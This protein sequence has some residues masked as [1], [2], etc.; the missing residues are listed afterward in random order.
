MKKLFRFFRF[1]FYLSK[2]KYCLFPLVFFSAVNLFGQNYNMRFKHIGIPEGLSNN[3]IT[4]INQDEYHYIWIAT[5]RGLNRFDGLKV[6]Q[7]IY[8]LDNN[9]NLLNEHIVDL[10]PNIDGG[11]WIATK[12]GLLLHKNGNFQ[13]YRIIE[14]YRIDI[15]KVVRIN[16]QNWFCTSYGIY[17]YNGETNNFKKIEIAE[18]SDSVYAF[19]NDAEI[20]TI[21]LNTE[22]D[23]LWICTSKGGIYLKSLKT[24]VI[25]PYKLQHSEEQ[26]SNNVF[27]ND[28]YEDNQKN[29]W[30][31]STQ[32]LWIKHSNDVANEKVSFPD[33]DIANNGVYSIAQDSEGK[34]WCS[35][36]D[37]GLFVIDLKNSITKRFSAED[38]SKL[39]LSSGFI[40]KIFIDSQDNL[41][42]GHQEVGIDYSITEYHQK[43]SYY[44]NV[45]DEQ[46]FVPTPVRKIVPINNEK[47]LVVY[48]EA[49]NPINK[50][51]SIIPIMNVVDNSRIAEIKHVKLNRGN[52][53]ITHIL[54][55]NDKFAVL[56]YDSIYLFNND[57]LYKDEAIL[58]IIPEVVLFET[59]VMFPYIQNDN[60]WILG[61]HLRRFDLKTGKEELYMQD[62]NLDRFIID[63]HGLLWGAAS[64]NGL[65][66]IDLK[67]KKVLAQFNNDPVYEKSISD[68]NINC[69][70]QD[71]E[72]FIWVGTEFGLNKVQP[73]I[74]SIIARNNGF[75]NE[76]LFKEI[77]FKRFKTTDG[78]SNNAVKSILEDN[79]KRLWLGTGN[80]ISIVDMST[81]NIFNLG[82]LE[83]IQ[84]G[85]FI[86]NSCTKTDDGTMCFGGEKGLN[87]FNPDSISFKEKPNRTIIN[88]L[89]IFNK[90]VSVGSIHRGRVILNQAIEETKKI[91]LSYKDKI[92][93]IGFVAVDFEH[94]NEIKYFYKLDGFDINWI[95]AGSENSVTYTKLLPGDYNFKV[96]AKNINCQWTEETNLII[97]VSTPFWATWLFRILI[98]IV[99]AYFIAF[100][101]R[102]R[103]NSIKRQKKKLETIVHQ[104]TE[105]LERAN[106]ELE[107]QKNEIIGQRD[108]LVELNQEI[109]NV[110]VQKLKFFTNISHELR[111]PLTLILAPIEK[112]IKT[113]GFEPF[114]QQSHNLIYRNAFRLLELI[115]QLLN[116]RKI[117]TGYMHLHTKEADIVLYIRELAKQF[118]EFALQRGQ[119]FEINSESDSIIT[120]FDDDKLGKILTNLLSNAMKYTFEGGKISLNITTVK[121]GYQMDLLEDTKYLMIEIVDTGIGISEKHINKIFERF[122][123]VEDS[124]QESVGTGIG[125]S[126]TKSLVE[127]HKGKITV[128]SNIGK[129]SCFRVLLPLGKDYLNENEKFNDK[130]NSEEFVYEKSYGLVNIY[131]NYESEDCGFYTNR[132]TILIVEDNLDL[133]H[134]MKDFLCEEYNVVLAYNGK[135]ALEKLDEINHINIIISDIMMPGLDGLSF[136]KKVKDNIHTS[137]LPVLLLTAKHGEESILEGLKTGADDYIIKPFS[138]EV[139]KAKLRNIIAH[140]N[141]LKKK[142]SK[143][144]SIEPSEITTTSR[145]EEFILKAMEVVE[146]NMSDSDFDIKMFASSLAMSPS[147]LLR[148]LKGI[149]GESSDKFIRSFRLKRAAQLLQKSQLLVTEICYDVGFTNQKHFST[150]FKNYFSLSPTEYQKK[151][152]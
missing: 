74:D 89:Q 84:E 121:E 107:E 19:L 24:N 91:E 147:T 69:I 76:G 21:L 65:K 87:I 15:H 41:W 50:G 44:N 45:K 32:G 16:N 117:E 110:N 35:V 38:D 90:I 36:A 55:L 101:V 140:R 94:P 25:R 61:E 109:K 79:K 123:Q 62:I 71:S 26:T 46:S 11:I 128:K 118:K 43:I 108:Q 102:F 137:H 56:T 40:N 42:L 85:N 151:Y 82:Y 145:D 27:I 148:K 77:K 127:L 97:N 53:D 98:M 95:Q 17:H 14:N 22:G 115:N 130:S 7:F 47:V 48:E 111:T 104:R 131:K 2:V 13:Q 144:L 150:A 124:N 103:L 80:G 39:N 133:C 66:I 125:L 20:L 49:E 23:N 30:F 64:N 58:S 68:N 59:Y 96:K 37:L 120:W 9:T 52:I 72:G 149:T 92:I 8:P 34:I 126:V 135:E 99:G 4:D 122:Y 138:E 60:F 119:I 5:K 75:Y 57:L 29:I 31:G 78:L 81:N 93:S 114:V 143:Q 86:E 3:H 152:R 112:L 134:F 1:F 73:N 129:G 54:F 136:C 88:E 10:E 116:F 105:D 100:Y 139:V 106:Y 141:N 28:I 63:D 146:E 6:N 132:D 142:Y 83:G 12:S 33:F 51:M 113:Q 67:N 70:Y 18:K